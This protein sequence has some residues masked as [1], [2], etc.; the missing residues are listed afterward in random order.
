MAR[1]G[2]CQVG[3][4]GTP[5]AQYPSPCHSLFGSL[6]SL[7]TPFQSAL[8]SPWM[9]RPR[10]QLSLPGPEVSGMLSDQPSDDNPSC[11]LFPFDLVILSKQVRVVGVRLGY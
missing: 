2:R 9:P 4:V 7:L 6:L 3:K 5:W 8:G 11:S 1:Y 10:H